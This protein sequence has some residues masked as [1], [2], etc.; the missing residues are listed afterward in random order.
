[1]EKWLTHRWK[2]II[3]PF[4][5]I[6]LWWPIIAPIFHTP[7]IY[8]TGGS[9]GMSNK[10]CQKN[11]CFLCSFFL[12]CITLYHR[13]KVYIIG[14]FPFKQNPFCFIRKKIRRFGY[15][16]CYIRCSIL[17]HIIFK[18]ERFIYT[19]ITTYS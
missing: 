12:Y 15:I 6:Y 11:T 10:N 13:L 3:K 5:K 4:N 19:Q 2:R 8:S 1:M 17:P 14:S 9:F 16:S 7:H 18:K